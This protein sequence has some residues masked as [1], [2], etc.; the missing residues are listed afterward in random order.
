MFLK[1]NKK[2]NYEINNV[3][4]YNYKKKPLYKYLH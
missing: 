3:I 4:Y 1:K 2:Y